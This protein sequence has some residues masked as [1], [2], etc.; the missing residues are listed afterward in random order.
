MKN[1]GICIEFQ[2]SYKISGFIVLFKDFSLIKFPSW[3]NCFVCLTFES[4]FIKGVN[5]STPTYD[6]TSGIGGPCPPGSYCLVG[7]EDPTPCPNT[8]YRDTEG[9][10]K[11][12]DCIPCKLGH[13]C[14]S[15]NLTDATAPCQKGFYCYRGNNVPDPTG[16]VFI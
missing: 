6:T 15:E 8:T 5:V 16:T 13:C 14:G 1:F 3:K 7:T 10:A 4:S 2:S 9:A 11:L 12:A